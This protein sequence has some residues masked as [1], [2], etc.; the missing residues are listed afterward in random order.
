MIIRDLETSERDGKRRLTATV[1]WEDNPF[2]EQTIFFETEGLVGE[3]DR[4]S[5]DAFLCGC[6]PS[7]TLHGEHRFRVEAA[8]CPMLVEG[9]KKAHAWWARW[10]GVPAAAPVI[11]SPPRLRS[12]ALSGPR[13]AAA[14]LSGG[15]DSLHMLLRNRQ[16]Y[17][18]D[19][20]AY[21]GDVLL[22]HG[23]DIGK[24]PSDPEE[25]RFRLI[26]WALEPVAARAHVR[27]MPC[28]TN[29]RRLPSIPG[30]WMYRQ[31][32]AALA[33]VGHSGIAAPAFLFLAATYNIAN[34]VPFGSHPALDGLYSSQQLTVLHEDLLAT[35]IEKL[36][37]LAAWP[38][39]LGALRV[40]A[41]EPGPVTNCGRCEKCLRT[42][43]E[44]LAAG[45]EETAAFGRSLTP[46][47]LWTDDVKVTVRWQAICYE[48]LLPFL[49]ERSLKELY[50]IIARK[51]AAF[52]TWERE[53]GLEWP[54]H[55]RGAA[56]T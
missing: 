44:L 45:I 2:P 29:L 46:S 3:G 42:R 56:A 24:R 13:R 43:L 49:W 26:R 53:G 5:V 32:G 51:V 23:F 50:A 52:R 54:S 4:A 21:I 55:P 8:P 33:A 20:P 14:F 40:C 22:I 6:F 18:R 30:Y 27:I 9:L 36:R 47:E 25:E 1:V 31:N 10:G 7:A 12:Q 34:A 35:R 28:R 15:V 39:A 11:E 37:N 41:A 16:I 17:H 19:D 38:E 48:D